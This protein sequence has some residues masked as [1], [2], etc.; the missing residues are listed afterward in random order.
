MK[1]WELNSILGK[2]VF[3]F[4]KIDSEN[5]LKKMRNLNSNSIKKKVNLP[6]NFDWRNING[7]N[8][9]SPVR[10]QQRCGSCYAFGATGMLESRASNL[11]LIFIKKIYFLFKNFKIGIYSKNT[12]KP[13]YSPQDV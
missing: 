4:R 13:I 1:N 8:F 9:V 3:N 11:I 2:K 12:Q 7:E 6:E 10:D 5:H